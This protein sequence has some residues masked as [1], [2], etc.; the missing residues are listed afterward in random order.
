MRILIVLVYR[1]LE[2]FEFVLLLRCI[3]SFFAGGGN[4]F[5]AFL[6]KITEPFLRPI[7]NALSRTMMG[8]GMFDF[9]PVVAIL[10][11]GVFERCLALISRLF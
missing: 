6:C 7:R 3:L 1:L 8:N 9:S 10:L 11:I 4:S 2:L 5:Y